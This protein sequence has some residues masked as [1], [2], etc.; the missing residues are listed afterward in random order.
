M[1]KKNEKRGNEKKGPPSVVW[2]MALHIPPDL[3]QEEAPCAASKAL[4][5]LYYPRK[6]SPSNNSRLFFIQSKAVALNSNIVANQTSCPSNL[7]GDVTACFSLP[8]PPR[9]HIDNRP[10]GAVSNGE[11]MTAE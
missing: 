11:L 1:E 6:Q 3:C 2:F 9:K 5:V 8:P 7:P 4:I 10:R